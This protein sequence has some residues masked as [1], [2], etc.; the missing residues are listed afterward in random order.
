[1]ISNGAGIGVLSLTIGVFFCAFVWILSF[2]YGSKN[3]TAFDTFCLIGALI[4]IVVYIFLKS[5]LL[6]VIFV[7]T[8]DM[9]GFLPTLRKI[10]QEPHT[11]TLSA[12][13]WFIIS[14]SLSVIAINTYSFINLI[15][16][17]SLI[18]ANTVCTLLIFWRRKAVPSP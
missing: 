14:G 3:I 2:K 4:S 10:Y 6:A 12:F 1:M 16:P 7:S 13:A 17:V 9:I 5:P 11:E 8:I 15:Y 18:A